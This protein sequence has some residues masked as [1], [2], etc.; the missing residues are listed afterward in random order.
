MLAAKTLFHELV[1]AAQDS[2]INLTNFCDRHCKTMDTYLAA[3]ALLE[4]QAS[5]V[6]LMVSIEQNIQNQTKKKILEDVL[7]RMDDDDESYYESE[8]TDFLYT[9]GMFPYSFGLKL[10]LQR[11]TSDNE[12][13]IEMLDVLGN[14]I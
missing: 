12:N 6:N 7:K 8:E 2:T 14:I 5:A 3:M 13:F 4:G 11:H 1:H 10:V 9:L